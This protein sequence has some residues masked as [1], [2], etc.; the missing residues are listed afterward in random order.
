MLCGLHGQ[1]CDHHHF[2]A[3]F[4][5]L[6]LCWQFIYSHGTIIIVFLAYDYYPPIILLIILATVMYLHPYY[7]D[8]HVVPNLEFPTKYQRYSPGITAASLRFVTIVSHIISLI[9]TFDYLTIFAIGHAFTCIL[10]LHCRR[11]DALV[12]VSI[13]TQLFT[14][15]PPPLWCDYTR[16]SPCVY[17]ERTVVTRHITILQ[18][19]Y[20]Y[21]CCIPCIYYHVSASLHPRLSLVTL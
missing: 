15:I 4:L 21:A 8:F 19:S 17:R 14:T 2:L 5:Y 18:S 9:V 13:I 16:Y 1:P 6:C 20:G 10:L 12:F 7:Y 11:H 3:I